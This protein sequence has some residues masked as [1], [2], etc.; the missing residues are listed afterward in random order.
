[1]WFT[2]DMAMTPTRLAR[3]LTTPAADGRF[4]RPW[5]RG[6]QGLP[7]AIAVLLIVTVLAQSVAVRVHWRGSQHGGPR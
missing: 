3:L 2:A 7:T 6:F 4:G 1:L 5:L